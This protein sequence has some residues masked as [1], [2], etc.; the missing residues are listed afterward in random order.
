M[1]VPTLPAAPRRR[2]R[3]LAQDVVDALTA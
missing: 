1:S 3:S 2:A